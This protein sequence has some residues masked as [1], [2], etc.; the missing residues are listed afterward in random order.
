MK[1]KP[2][3]RKCKLCELY[4]E[5]T[6]VVISDGGIRK[7]NFVLVGEGPGQEEDEQGIA[8]IG[9]TGKFLRK[10]IKK[11]TKLELGK[12]IIILNSVSCRPPGNRNPKSDEILACRNWLQ[13][14]LSIIQPKFI[15]AAGKFAAWT[16]IDEK[17]DRISKGIFYGKKYFREEWQLD[18]FNF[19]VLHIWHPGY[20]WR[21]RTSGTL[22]AWNRQMLV[23]VDMVKNGVL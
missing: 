11:N 7:C 22:S 5:R 6:Q 16:F 10:Y 19:K 4:K 2:D 20:V 15:I 1:K 13:L 14:N 23:F 3:Q 21:N 18:R 12:D 9:T 17:P 8:F